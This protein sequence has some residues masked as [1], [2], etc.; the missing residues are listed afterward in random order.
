M[1]YLSILLIAALL[2][3]TGCATTAPTQQTVQKASAAIVVVA[4]R[5]ARY[6]LSRDP[7]S[8]AYFEAAEVALTVAL[9]DGDYNPNHLE[10][11]LRNI[12]INEIKK[13]EIA[14][15]IG[16]ALDLYRI[17]YGDSIGQK[18]D[19]VSYLRPILT[20]FR[21]GISLALKGN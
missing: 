15:A 4:K 10:D 19:Q 13:P 5:G 7:N 3:I 21:D 12:S 6:E 9:A 2:L 17:E 18:I 20:S 16:A 11:A 8:R 14:E 1:K